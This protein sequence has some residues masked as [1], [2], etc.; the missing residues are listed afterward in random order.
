MKTRIFILLA[1]VATMIF[2]SCKSERKITYYSDIYAEKPTSIYI[3]PVVDKSAR[4]PNKLEKEKAYNVEVE[5]AADYFMKTLPKPLISQGYYVNGPLVAAEIGSKETRSLRQL[6]RADLTSYYEDYGVDAV[7]F[8]TIHRW[9]ESNGKWTVYIE[10]VLRSTKS[11]N[12]LMH[13]WVEASKVIFT[14]MKGDPVPMRDDRLFAKRMGIDNGT[15][16]RCILVSNVNSVV[17]KDLPVSASQRQFER[18]Q[19]LGTNSQYLQVITNET[20]EI[21]SAPISMEAFEDACFT[22]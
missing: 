1:V 16:Q 22:K 8:T 6:L 9:K 2:S 19:H 12:E 15:A 14:D 13:T 3:A 18:D 17:L 5:V 11:Y 10:Y 4:K 21:E 20:G 7:L